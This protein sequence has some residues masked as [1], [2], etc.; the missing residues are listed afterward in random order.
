MSEQ[1]AEMHDDKGTK[2]YINGWLKWAVS[3]VIGAMWLVLI[4]MAQGY[5]SSN[6]KRQT[7]NE[8]KVEKNAEE[9]VQV[10]V[11]LSRVENKV[12]NTEKILKEIKDLLNKD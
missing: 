6:D 4:L 5:T 9:I 8:A 11:I 2:I 3:G 1:V 10:R 12:D 7:K